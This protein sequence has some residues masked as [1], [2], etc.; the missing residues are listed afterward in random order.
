MKH[1]F[2]MVFAAL[3]LMFAAC[4]KAD[5][6]PYSAADAELKSGKKV[7]NFRAHLSGSEEV[8]VNDSKATGQ[9]IFQLSKDS[10]ELSYKLILANIENF[11]MAHIHLAVAGQNGPIV[12]WLYP[13]APPAGPA[14]PGKT[15]GVVAEGII[16]ASNLM[17]LLG[18]KQVSDLVET[19]MAGNAYVNVH[20]LQY[21]GGEI[22]GQIR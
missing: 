3:V 9:A 14:I 8:P 2:P 5:T 21:P 15:N 16:T 4:E 7:M 1:L 18:G 13:S 19:I 22:R 11:R 12:V 17:G 20:T 6:E 10:T